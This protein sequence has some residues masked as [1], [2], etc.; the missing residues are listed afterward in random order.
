MGVDLYVG[1]HASRVQG[2]AQD[3]GGKRMFTAAHAPQ[4]CA[5]TDTIEGDLDSGAYT[6]VMDNKRLTYEAALDRQLMFERKATEKWGVLFQ[7]RRLVSYDR[8]IDEKWVAGER[9]KERWTIKDGDKAVEETIAAATYLASRRAD[10]SPRGLI[11]SCQGVDAFQYQE[12]MV[13]V[14]KLATPDDCIGLGGWCILGMRRSW[15]PT[16][17]QTLR[18]ILPMIA[19]TDVR[20][21][22]IFGV[23]YQPALGG[24]LWLADQYKMDDGSPQFTV[25]TD[26]TAPILACTW[27][28]WKKAGARERYW[29]DNVAW[30]QNTLGNLRAS[31]HY[32]EPP[33]LEPMRQECFL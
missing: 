1:G 18:L 23:L 27:K 29:R 6:D 19:Q 33:Q 17:W 5:F 20:R 14:L 3:L 10:L 9:R 13:E 21:I 12:C 26:S 11:L 15:M 30:W 24:L 28:N 2:E 8:L 25:S 7:A 32:E 31:E 4:T 16:F 22:H